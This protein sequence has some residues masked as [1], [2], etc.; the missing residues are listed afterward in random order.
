M[1]Q[2]PFLLTLAYARGLQYW[3]E[4]LIPLED[5]NFCPLAGSVVELREMV[6]KHIMLTNWDL[7][8]NLGEA[9]NQS[10]LASSSSKAVLPL[11]GKSDTSFTEATT[12]TI[13]PTATNNESIKHTTPLVG[14]E[15]EN[16]YLLV[17]TASIGQLSLESASNG[18]KGSTTA[19]C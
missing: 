6:K 14:M 8:Q 19:P 3:A 16:W 5:P 15:G 18:P 12:Q 9:G 2:Q 1:Q 7:L 10:P 13:S 4:M 11:G 17:I